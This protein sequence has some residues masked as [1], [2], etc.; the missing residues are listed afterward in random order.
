MDRYREALERM[1]Y[2]IVEAGTDRIVAVRNKWYWD[3]IATNVTFAVFVQVVTS[4]DAARIEADVDRL[5]AEVDDLDPSKLPQGLQKGRVVLP[6]YVA[7]S[8]TP[9][10]RA[11]LNSEMKLRFATLVFP[12]ALDSGTGEVFYLRTT[13]VFGSVYYSKLRFVAQSLLEPGEAPNKEPFSVPGALL[14]GGLLFLLLLT[15]PLLAWTIRL[16]VTI[17]S[18]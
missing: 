2:A 6:V 10:A 14:G 15:V 9:D 1:G 5:I 7:V 13:P 16:L 3:C 17:M 4:L 18:H 8:V 12:A 11:K